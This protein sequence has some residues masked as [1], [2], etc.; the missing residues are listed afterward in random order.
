M[1][2]S[3]ITIV[4]NN[5]D[6]IESAIKSVI[7]QTYNNIEYIVIDGASND[8]TTD[9]IENY[10]DHI[11]Y[12]KSEP[13]KG[14]YNALNKGIKVATGEIIGILHSDDLLFESST[15]EKVVNCFRANMSDMI[16]ASGQYVAKNDITQIKR[17]YKGKPFKNWTLYYG[18]VPLH[19]TMY[20][21]K[22][23]YDVYGLYDE[24]YTIASDYELTL[25]LLRKEEIKKTFLND[26]VVKM[27]L[28]GKSTTINLQKKKSS[29]DYKII[30]DY[31]LLGYFTLLSKIIRKIKQYILP[32]ILKY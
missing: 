22:E 7:N 25:R 32:R 31:N 20:I 5:R 2:V 11:S 16:Y 26:W 24:S 19:T 13:D 4:Y 28:G 21:K 3:I 14:L 23:L 8:G 18:W 12:F 29:E 15:I 6:S 17:V 27:R 9:I 30:K 10:L 1:K